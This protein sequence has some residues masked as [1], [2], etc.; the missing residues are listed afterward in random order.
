VYHEDAGRQRDVDTFPDDDANHV[1][2]E[3]ILALGPDPVF[4]AEMERLRNART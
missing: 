1:S 3:S 4:S 2:S